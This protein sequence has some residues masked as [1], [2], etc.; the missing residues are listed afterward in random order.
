MCP[1]MQPIASL[2][3]NEPELCESHIPFRCFCMSFSGIW[4]DSCHLCDLPDTNKARDGDGLVLN[5]SGANRWQ[6]FATCI[7]KLICK[8]LTE[9]TLYV[10]GLIHT[11]FVKA[12]CSLVC[13]GGVD[14][15]MVSYY[16]YISL[17]FGLSDRLV[18]SLVHLIFFE[19]VMIFGILIWHLIYME[20]MLWICFSCRINPYFQHPPICGPNTVNHPPFKCR[21]RTSCV[22]VCSHMS[23]HSSFVLFWHDCEY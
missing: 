14:V 11:S 10:Q 9:G 13:F 18:V 1:D 16:L 22:Q 21:W 2:H 3:S 19:D 15:Q 5:L 4:G 7:L 23:K 17:W 20:G 12:A 8:C 6:H